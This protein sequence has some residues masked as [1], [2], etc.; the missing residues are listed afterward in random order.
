MKRALKNHYTRIM[1]H[2]NGD[3][4][5]TPGELATAMGMTLAE[6]RSATSNLCNQLYVRGDGGRN[7][8]RYRLTNLGL[9]HLE[10][11]QRQH[12]HA[13]EPIYEDEAARV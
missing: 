2:L 6:A 11:F 10:E 8:T 13:P 7:R 1:A 3:P 9:K 12:D 5:L 4:G